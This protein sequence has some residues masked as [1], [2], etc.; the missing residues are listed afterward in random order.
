V[1]R[2]GV[3][4]LGYCIEALGLNAPDVARACQYRMS[5]GISPLDPDGTDGTDGTD[6]GCIV[7]RW[8]LRI[9]ATITADHTS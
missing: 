3:Q 2:D 6:G 4:R 7:T 5:A 8:N 1:E 9:D